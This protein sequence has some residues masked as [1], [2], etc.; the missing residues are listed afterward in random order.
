MT[1]ELEEEEEEKKKKRFISFGDGR[2]G[3][4]RIH[5]GGEYV[6]AKVKENEEEKT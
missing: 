5:H 3:T 2:I 4:S 6:Y 1:C